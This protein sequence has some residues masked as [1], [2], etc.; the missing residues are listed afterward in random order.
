[1]VLWGLGLPL[2]IL[3]ILGVMCSFIKIP[4][5]FKQIN[6]FPSKAGQLIAETDNQILLTL[7]LVWTVG[8]FIYQGLQFVKTMRYFYLVYPFLAILSANFLFVVSLKV[9]KRLLRKS[10]VFLSLCFFVFMSLMIW[11]LSFITI[12][13][14]PHSRVQASEWIYD[15]I[16]K[17]STLSCEHWDD[18]LP[19]PLGEKGSLTHYN[20]EALEMYN[21]DN[22]EK[23][24]KINWQLKQVDYLILSSN[25]LWESI[26]KVP[27]KYP[28]TSKFY[29]DLFDQ[30]LQFRK[31]V[32]F[33]SY[34]S[35]GIEKCLPHT[36]WC[37]GKLEI[38]DDLAEEAFTVYDHP[39]IIIFKKIQ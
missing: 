18:C 11:P 3:S 29:K 31:V 8:L 14:R 17:G 23:W 26:P 4:K 28:T 38:R 25:R 16:P 12:Y 34:P 13:S 1:M 7:I 35:L 20:I 15:N 36:E 33:T 10:Y 37:W 19:V 24:E 2:G 30:K 5:R 6:K 9:K 22:R 21:R 39:K 32:E 27:E